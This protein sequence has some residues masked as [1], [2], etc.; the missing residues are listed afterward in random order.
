VPNTAHQAPATGC[1][2][3]VVVI[4]FIAQFT[5]NLKWRVEVLMKGHYQELEVS[6]HRLLLN[7]CLDLLRT[8]QWRGSFFCHCLQKRNYHG[9]DLFG[10]ETFWLTGSLF[11]YSSVITHDSG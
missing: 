11:H 8:N 3:D 1:E 10:K 7:P 9:I 6:L 5:D 2:N 4:Q